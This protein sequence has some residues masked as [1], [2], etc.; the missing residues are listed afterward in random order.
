VLDLMIK[1]CLCRR[2]KSKH[3][4]LEEENK[5]LKAST[6]SKESKKSSRESTPLDASAD[7]ESSLD[8]SEVNF[9]LNYFMA[10]YAQRVGVAGIEK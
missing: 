2:L 1:F 3:L 10:V 9:A 6:S 4:Q 7:E 8:L 5:T